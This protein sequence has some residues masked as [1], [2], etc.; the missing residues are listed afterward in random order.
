M[1]LQ[2]RCPNT[3]TPNWVLKYSK[4]DLGPGPR[5]RWRRVVRC[6]QM[7]QWQYC[8]WR[9]HQDHMEDGG[10]K[11]IW[12]LAHIGQDGYCPLQPKISVDVTPKPGCVL[13]GPR[14]WA[15]DPGR[16]GISSCTLCL[17]TWASGPWSR[18]ALSSAT[19]S[20]S[21]QMAQ[22]WFLWSWAADIVFP[23]L[24]LC[25]QVLGHKHPLWKKS[26]DQ[27]IQHIKKQDI[28]L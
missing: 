21:Q 17:H 7:W 5:W 16:S 26:Y 10:R 19:C 23:P 28:T 6:G 4:S 25:P 18:R 14:T 13:F 20:S 11:K 1:L 24:C 22:A 27:P 8:H 12:V 9:L 3:E 2:L 15:P